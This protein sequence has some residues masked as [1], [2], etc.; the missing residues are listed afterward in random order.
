MRAVA[1]V[2]ASLVVAACGGSGAAPAAPATSP[3][4]PAPATA[5]AR[6]AFLTATLTDVRT[7]E[8]F[9]IGGFPGKVTLVLAMA[10]W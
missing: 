3:G 7:G 6:P 5:A 9:T 2:L 8:R 4:L 1:V 10:V